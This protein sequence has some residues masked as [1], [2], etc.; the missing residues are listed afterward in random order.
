MKPELNWHNRFT[1]QAS[2][3]IS[4]RKYLYEQVDLYHANRVLEVGCGTGAIL[5]DLKDYTKASIHGLDLDHMRLLEACMN[6]PIVA[7]AQ[8]NAFFLPYPSLSFD[9]TFCHFFLL[10]VKSPLE[11]LME[12]RRVTRPGGA[13]LLMAEPDYD[14]RVDL[15][16]ELEAIGLLQNQALQKQGADLA[17][18]S[19]LSNLIRQAGINLVEGGLLQKEQPGSWEMKSSEIEWEVL[20]SDLEG[21]ESPAT[22]ASLKKIDM[23]ARRSGKRVLNIPTYFAFG[24]V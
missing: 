13:V 2:W 5:S 24:R 10:W 22:M 12:M 21:T 14:H 4:L 9:V 17:M 11:V 23:D 20:E 16:Q 8:G 3:T 15:P 19:K 6:A 7:Y 18:G 1:Q